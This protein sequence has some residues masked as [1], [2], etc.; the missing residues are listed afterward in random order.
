M[1]DPEIDLIARS[2]KKRDYF[3]KSSLGTRLFRLEPGSI[4]LG[5]ITGKDHAFLDEVAQERASRHPLRSAR[6]Q[7]TRW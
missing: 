7:K 1:S 6:A 3:Y 2:Q 5:L 4:Q